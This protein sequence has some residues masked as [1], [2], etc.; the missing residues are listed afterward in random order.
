M[1]LKEGDEVSVTVEA[2]VEGSENHKTTP[3]S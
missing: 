1:A 2:P 3:K